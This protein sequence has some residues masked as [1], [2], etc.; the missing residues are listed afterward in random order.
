MREGLRRT[1]CAVAGCEELFWVGLSGVAG[2][3]EG[4]GHC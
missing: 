1:A 3:A 4:L 2:A